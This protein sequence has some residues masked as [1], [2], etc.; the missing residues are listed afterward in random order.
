MAVAD[1]NHDSVL[2]L[3]VAGDTGGGGNELWV[4]LGI[5][6]GLFEPGVTYATGPSPN[7]VV[8]VDLN[9]DGSLDIATANSDG[10]ATL[11]GTVTLLFGDGN[12]G[13]PIRF[14]VPI[15]SPIY[16]RAPVDAALSITSSD[17]N[18]NG[19][20]DLAVGTS[21]GVVIML[22]DGNGGF[23][24]LVDIPLN[25]NIWTIAAS[26]LNLD[27]IKDLV[28]QDPNG[29]IETQLGNG[30]GTF[31]APRGFFVA[32]QGLPSLAVG[33]LNEDGFPDVVYAPIYRSI[34]DI[35]V[36]LG[37]GDGSLR[38]GDTPYYDALGAVRPV[39]ADLNGDLHLDL[40]VPRPNG[41]GLVS[42]FEGDGQGSFHDAGTMSINAS[43][44]AAGDFDGDGRA[45]LGCGVFGTSPQLQIFRNV[46]LY[47]LRLSAPMS[48]EGA[49]GQHM[50]FD[51]A[52]GGASGNPISA[53]G[54]SGL[55][56][57]ASFVVAP[58]NLSGRFEWTPTFGQAG[59]FTV[60]FRV[61][62]GAGRTALA[63]TLVTILNVNRPPTADASG[64]YTGIADVPLAF[65]GSRSADPDGNPL[66]YA[67]DFGDATTGN[68]P[69]PDHTYV[70]TG[71]FTVTLTV[72]DNGTPPLSD[73]DTSAATITQELAAN[74]FQT[75]T[76]EIKPKAGKPRYCFQIEP[77]DGDYNN[78]D[79]LLSSVKATF[80]GV[81]VSADASRTTINYDLN[82][83][84]VAE[85][86]ACFTREAIATLF[87][88]LPS[89]RNTA[90]FRITGD[91]SAGGRFGDDIT[92]VVR[93]PVTGSALAASVSPNPLNPKSTIY[94]ATT[95][96]GDVKVD[97]FDL[98]GRL[99]RTFQGTTF[100][101]AGSHELA[102]DGLDQRGAHLA[103]GVY[104]LKIQSDV[105]GNE[106]K[107][108]TILR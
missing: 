10:P 87:A 23:T 36:F 102:I 83:N 16:G 45:D 93:G 21:S 41:S 77:V 39:L 85:I 90:T 40:V 72:T 14:D 6:A 3:V 63:T 92:V 46:T 12:G 33:D 81:T 59:T 22:N 69:T 66:T 15:I 89:G 57:G 49:E 53:L 97:M 70:A 4:H 58:D 73:S 51:V 96:P 19:H 17:F 71:A 88:G 24:Q 78:S 64:P 13:F 56:P 18:G 34:G 101:A 28:F 26:D 104:Y 50:A 82:L 48:V 31:K 65:D 103:S 55:P 76:G 20:Q 98:Q 7:A 8:C 35:T 79:V 54:A 61:T 94:F 42:L 43:V 37:D 47:P 60:G 106:T 105:D 25:G 84:G 108:I 27:G 9:G 86:R 91:L 2:D 99:V 32:P 67:W 74:V 30:D 80:N 100:M 11:D 68:G 62:D 52:V 29:G 107:T 95:K 1:L 5:G 75:N 44:I 38:L